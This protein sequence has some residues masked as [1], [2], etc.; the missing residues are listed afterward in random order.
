MQKKSKIKVG[1]IGFGY[2]GPNLARNFANSSLYSLEYISDLNKSRL[3]LAAELYP[4]L[5]VTTSH[6]EVI[7]SKNVDLVA[8][9]TPVF[10]H[11]ELVKKSLFGDKH[12][13]VEKPFTYTSKQADELIKLADQKRKI[14][15]VDHTF[16][17]TGAVKKIKE[18]VDSGALGSIYYYDSMRVNLG[19]FQGDVNVVWDLAPHDFSIMDYLVGKTPISIS[20]CG[21]V[22][23][24]N[25]K[26]DVSYIT[27]F[28]DNNLI[29][30]FNVNWLS[31]VKIRQT[32][33]AG[34]KSMVVWD[35]LQ[36]DA[37][38]KV[39]D[40]GV[41]ITEKDGIYN[42]MASYRM[43]QMY[44]PV[45]KHVEALAE[46]IKYLA[47]CINTGVQ[48]FNNASSGRRIVRMLEVTN[49]S[50]AKKG[51]PVAFD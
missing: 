24:S 18:M 28:Y 48:P 4:N 50:L 25:G 36:T 43:G 15:M 11:Y 49:E 22:H 6:D 7:S 46:E 14:V 34:D 1:L 19:L 51:V 30:H 5:V 26:E 44:A 21:A 33:I 38:V 31:P 16:L 8:I 23:Y 32:L 9:A 12:V 27:A 2:W 40:R 13:F 35:D 17:F 37:A 42:L 29:A 47:E 45:I 20:A 41:E 3:D 10:T 39:Y